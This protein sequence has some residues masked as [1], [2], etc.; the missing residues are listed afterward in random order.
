MSA[1]LRRGGLAYAS[2]RIV[3]EAPGQPDEE[4]S[5]TA[6]IDRA[7]IRRNNLLLVSGIAYERR[8]HA[9]LGPFDDSFAVYWDWD[10]Y[11][12]LAAAGVTFTDCGERGVRISARPD[13]ASAAA[14]AAMRQAELDRLCAKH[15]LHGIVLKNHESIAVEQQAE[16][17]VPSSR[18]TAERE[19]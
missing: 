11:L 16:A 19:P 4:L 17:G 18:R 9:D 13:T 1:A 10:W 2:G 7:S 12:R 3:R 5:F 8:L 14:R 6:E 15:G